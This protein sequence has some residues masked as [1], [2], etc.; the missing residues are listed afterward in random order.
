MRNL[1][2]TLTAA[3][4]LGLTL[5]AAP[6][7]AAPTDLRPEQLPRGAD[8]RVP[9]LEGNTLVDGSRRIEV[10]GVA[11]ELL[12][13]AAR[14]YVVRTRVT[15]GINGVR[16]LKVRPNGSTR[17]LVRR[18]A[19]DVTVNDTGTHL[20]VASL[21]SDGTTSIAVSRIRD[22]RRVA[23]REFG[24]PGGATYIVDFSGQRLLLGR[25][26]SGQT[27]V[28]NWASDHV[29]TVAR[30][31]RWL[32][33]GNLEGNVFAAFRTVN[34]RCTVVARISRPGRVLWKNCD[35]RVL[36]FSEDG[37]TMATTDRRRDPDYQTVRHVRIRTIRGRL[38]GDYTASSFREIQWESPR[39]VLFS[40]RDTSHTSTVRC[41]PMRC[42]N[43]STPTLIGVRDREQNS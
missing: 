42:K 6:S 24:Y 9:H 13:V 21:V 15:K 29:R 41:T 11:P 18:D 16:V 43:A 5:T 14:G 32:R 1:G 10:E 3:L 36:S 28:W 20:A 27:H 34:E 35:E 2:L 7:P 38:L 25:S 22:G 12:A 23:R 39:R 17:V 4:C 30:H 33:A 37:R 31:H 19:Y 40:V 26:R 8:A